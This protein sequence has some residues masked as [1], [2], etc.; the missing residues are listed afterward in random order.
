MK[1]Y[2]G[3]PFQFKIAGKPYVMQAIGFSDVEKV[4]GIGE[5]VGNDPQKAIKAI[6]GLI[7]SKS[8]AKTADAVMAGLGPKQI[9]ELIK[10]WSG[11]TPGESETS[12]DE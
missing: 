5:M 12:G 2:A 10:D 8:N 4:V 9:L 1:D 7:V 6:R 3:A 11:L